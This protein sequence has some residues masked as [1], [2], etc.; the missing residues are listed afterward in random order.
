M[1]IEVS[2]STHLPR[3]PGLDALTAGLT[4]V[5]AGEGSADRRLTVLH[6]EPNALASTFPSE[7]VTCR[8]DHENMLRLLCKYEG[9]HSHSSHG[10]RGGVPYE[11]AVYREVLQSSPVAAP[12]FY[13]A[14][15]DS[16]TG[17]TWLILEYLDQSVRVS[18]RP[19]LGSMELAARWIGQFHAAKERRLWTTPL[20]FL[21]R[22]DADY[23]L[24]WA[25]R[26][27]LFAADL[28]Q[29]PPWLPPLCQRFEEVV[30]LLLASPPTVIHG[31]YYP[32]N[33]LFRD[34]AVY[35]VD[36][37]SAA[38]A[39]GEIDLAS[40]VEGWSAEMVQQCEAEYQR[41]RWP[42][43]A[44]LDFAR[45]LEAARLYW[46]FRWLGDRST[47]ADSLWYLEQLRAVGERQ[48]LV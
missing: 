12:R 2:E 25:R 19:H 14:H 20:L 11:A 38:V 48:G 46:C 8:L 9:G 21:R 40:L 47:D 39:A 26:T 37:E 15:T 22:Y 17:E 4:S 27:A 6:R 10:H 23:Y 16:T 5:L 33:I 43:G 28:P 36:W 3:V 13:G 18:K 31:E 29:C 24:G 34:G 44:P 32:K 7:I 1:S 45:T 41:A 30:E 35:P 42:E